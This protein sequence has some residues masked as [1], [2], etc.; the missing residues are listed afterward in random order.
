MKAIDLRTEYLINPLG[1]GVKNPILSWNASG[2]KEQTAYQVVAYEK[3]KVIWD[4]SK[5]NSSSMRISFPKELH[6]GERITWNV[7]LWNENDV[8]GEKSED[9]FFE[10]SLLSPDDFKAKWISEIIT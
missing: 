7:V 9:A 10:M 3:G 8:K 5:V 1:I 4:S 2:D 6:S